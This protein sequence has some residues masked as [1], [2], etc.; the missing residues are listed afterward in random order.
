MFLQLSVL[1]Q[2]ILVTLYDNR[3]SQNHLDMAKWYVWLKQPRS[4]DS[5]DWMI[6]L[7][8]MWPVKAS[9][10]W[11]HYISHRG[12]GYPVPNILRITIRKLGN[13]FRTNQCFMKWHFGKT[14]TYSHD[15]PLISPVY[16]H[17][18]TTQVKYRDAVVDRK[19]SRLKL[20]SNWGHTMKYIIFRHTHIPRYCCVYHIISSLYPIFCT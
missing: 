18:S 7:K 20:T 2:C 8:N 16:P 4:S 3:T 5:C 12:V 6:W 19:I 17:S 1:K 14:N 10:G 13:P 15:I 9:G 11:L